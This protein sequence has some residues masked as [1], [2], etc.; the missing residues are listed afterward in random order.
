MVCV[1]SSEQLALSLLSEHIWNS[2]QSH[3]Q[4]YFHFG[5]GVNPG[6]IHSECIPYHERHNLPRIIN[7]RKASAV[8][9]FTYLEEILHLG[10]TNTF[11]RVSRNIWKQPHACT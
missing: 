1:D 2:K 11:S 6:L 3:V 4:I 8:F 10:K 7:Q 9:S 5:M